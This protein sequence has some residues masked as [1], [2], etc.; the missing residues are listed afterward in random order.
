MSSLGLDDVSP[1]ASELDEAGEH[2]SL[3][4]REAM[5]IERDADDICMTFLL[6]R[7]L[8]DEGWEMPFDGEV[9]SVV[10]GGAFVRF[11]DEGF[12]GFLPARMIR[13]DWWDLNEQETALV[14]ERTGNVIRLG[15]PVEVVVRRVD[16]PRGRV[17]LAPAME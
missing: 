8:H 10:G 5:Q 15:D 2:S 3:R 7:R 11:G 9:V 16:P 1:R 6:E 4:E 14:G 12:E 17:D 13:G